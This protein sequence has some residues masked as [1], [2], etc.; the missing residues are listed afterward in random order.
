MKMYH[1][2]FQVL[3]LQNFN[4][5]HS[6]ISNYACDIRFVFFSNSDQNKKYLAKP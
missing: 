4:Y 6:D 1:Y 5:L 2:L 3:T